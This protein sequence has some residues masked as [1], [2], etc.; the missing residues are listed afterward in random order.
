MFHCQRRVSESDAEP[1]RERE[2]GIFQQAF[3]KPH[4]NQTYLG[5]CSSTNGCLIPPGHSG[6]RSIFLHFNGP[7]LHHVHP[8]GQVLLSHRASARGGRAR[9]SVRFARSLRSPRERP[10]ETMTNSSFYFNAAWDAFGGR[11]D[12]AWDALLGESLGI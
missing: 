8:Q 2:R 1:A 5:P 12:A 3:H 10:Q 11:K 6:D 9:N 7:P 4:E